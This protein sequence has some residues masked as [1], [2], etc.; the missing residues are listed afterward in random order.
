MD[1]LWAMARVCRMEKVIRPYVESLPIQVSG[2][3]EMGA[4]LGWIRSVIRA[5]GKVRLEAGASTGDAID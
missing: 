1:E 2:T 5:G 4:E 3:E